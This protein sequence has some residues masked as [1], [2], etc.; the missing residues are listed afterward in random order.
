MVQVC[1]WDCKGTDEM[2]PTHLQD[3]GR[4][5]LEFG[6]T[7]HRIVTDVEAWAHPDYSWEIFIAIPSGHWWVGE[8]VRGESVEDLRVAIM[9]RLIEGGEGL[10]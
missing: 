3:L 7:P 2:S 1:D 4:V 9:A 10:E 5:C 8:G 6:F